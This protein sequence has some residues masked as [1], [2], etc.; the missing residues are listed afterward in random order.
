MNILIACEESQ[1]VCKAFREK[2]HN[3]YSCDI[4]ECSGGHPEWHILNDALEI[5]KSQEFKTMDGIM[6]YIKKW[7]LMIAHP[8]CTHLAISGAS[9]FDKKRK[10]GEQEKAILFFIELLNSNI[11]KICVENPVG[12]ISGKYISKHY[13]EIC[14]KFGLPIKPTQ[15]IHPWQFGDSYEKTTCLWLKNLKKLNPTN[16]TDKGEFVIF[17][18]GKKMPKWYADAYKYPKELRSKIR[19]KTPKGIATAMAEQWG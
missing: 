11:E 3:A 16:I 1:E 5:V 9:W 12:I 10:S 7:D 13:I 2:G 14:K 6:H 15:I 17:E 4:Q 19:S 8:P 18:S